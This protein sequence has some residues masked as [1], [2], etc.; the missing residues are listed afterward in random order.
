M[1]KKNNKDKKVDLL[2]DVNKYA[3]LFN[4]FLHINEIKNN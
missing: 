2:I 3:V 4:L 1:I